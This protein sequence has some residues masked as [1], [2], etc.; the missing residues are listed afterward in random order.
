MGDIEITNRVLKLIDN[1]PLSD[2]ALTREIPLGNGIIG[3]WRS[4]KQK[5]SVLA[6]SKISDYFGVTTD[7]IIKG[8]DHI[9]ASSLTNDDTD[10]LSIIHR[11]PDGAKEKLRSEMEI[12]LKY[13]ETD[14]TEDAVPIRQ[15]K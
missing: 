5:P 10:W 11:L 8:K 14:D 3:K 13:T 1:S 6:I 4:G 2:A 7:F 12:V 15:A 9:V